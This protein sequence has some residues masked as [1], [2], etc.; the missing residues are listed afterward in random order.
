MSDRPPTIADLRVKL[1]YICRDEERDATAPP[2]AWV[3]PCTCTLI[4]H[5][6][7]LLEWIKS[8]EGTG[9]ESSARQCPQCKTQYEVESNNPIVLKFLRAID[10][11]VARA[12]I[13]FYLAGIYFAI[14]AVYRAQIN[15]GAWAL[16]KYIGDEMFD[17]LLGDDRSKWPLIAKFNVVLIP[18][19]L[20]LSRLGLGYTI[21]ALVATWPTFAFLPADWDSHSPALLELDKPRAAFPWPPSP[22]VF[23]FVVLPI[24]RRLYN[25]YF[26][27][28]S[29]WVLDLGPAP[30]RPRNNPGVAGF[31]RRFL[32]NID[33]AADERAAAE[34][35]RAGGGN[36]NA[37]ENANANADAPANPNPEERVVALEM[38]HVGSLVGGA[39]L[40]PLISSTMGNLLHRLAQRFDLLKRFLAIRPKW[41]GFLPPPPLRRYTFSEIWK[42]ASAGVVQEDAGR[43]LKFVLRAV[44]GDIRKL[45]ECDPVWWRNSVGL[46]IFVVA[47]DFLQLLHLWLSKRE[48][49]TRRVKSRD[50]SGVDPREL[51]LLPTGLRAPP[52]SPMPRLRP[53]SF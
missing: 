32:D 7:C 52:S 3:H 50:F 34:G 35:G 2:R 9:R 29:R 42:R 36:A 20:I 19:G 13:G 43:T 40:V 53:G 47:K 17:L 39:L 23:G 48:L 12:D 15:Y 11:N 30:P 1:C 38:R 6:S 18:A 25:Y 14:R 22:L 24:T 41:R 4:A 46:G 10:K 28:F 37:A 51:D 16:R 8:S 31:L 45:D 27:V 44:W 49:A 21:S 5:E 33:R 26:T